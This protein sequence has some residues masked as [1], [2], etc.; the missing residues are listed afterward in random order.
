MNV[1]SAK[2]A[3][4]SVTTKRKADAIFD[5]TSK[6][7]RTI[8]LS[9]ENPLH[10]AN[11]FTNI[12]I[13]TDKLIVIRT[14]K[15]LQNDQRVMSAFVRMIPFIKEKNT[16]INIK[17][18]LDSNNLEIF[19]KIIQNYVSYASSPKRT[20]NF[21]YDDLS[22][23]IEQWLFAVPRGVES[24]RLFTDL[25]N[26]NLLYSL[27][28]NN[29][30]FRLS[31]DDTSVYI[32]VFI[33]ILDLPRGVDLLHRT[34]KE[35]INSKTYSFFFIGLLAAIKA[36]PAKNSILAQLF[37]ISAMVHPAFRE[38]AQKHSLNDVVDILV[39]CEHLKKVLKPAPQGPVQIIVS[40]AKNV[41]PP[42]TIGE[43]IEWM[44][45]LYSSSDDFG[46]HILFLSNQEFSELLNGCLLLEAIRAAEGI[47]F[48]M[49][50]AIHSQNPTHG[51]RLLS[52]LVD[53]VMQKDL[54]GIIAQKMLSAIKR[55]EDKEIVF[56][57]DFDKV[58]FLYLGL[59][60]EKDVQQKLLSLVRKT[61]SQNQAASLM[62]FYQEHLEAFEGK[63]PYFFA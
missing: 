62:R 5:E 63:L 6:K 3:F 55:L 4:V 20:F 28:C 18:S 43:K 7:I 52:I 57:P 59:I 60:E 14:L 31:N 35:L 15:D 33:R 32:E 39:E 25:D 51:T 42:S 22:R 61:F 16:V 34:L 37:P 27:L 26:A 9:S 45:F 30:L 1:S 8:L 47:H 44:A 11:E 41:P 24:Q 10:Q 23:N 29:Q 49:N 40:A 56:T 17:T 54:Q 50:A 36:H 53:F 21:Y 12:S 13:S 38:Y 46:K 48:L 19:F 2:S 58:F